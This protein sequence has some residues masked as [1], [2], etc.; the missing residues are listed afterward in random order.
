[1]EAFARMVQGTTEY[2]SFFRDALH[3]PLE[4][5]GPVLAFL[6]ERTA[7]PIALVALVHVRTVGFLA[8]AT[9]LRANTLTP[10]DADETNVVRQEHSGAVDREEVTIDRVE[11]GAGR[12]M[13][14]VHVSHYGHV[15]G[16]I[17]CRLEGKR[18]TN[19]HLL[20]DVLAPRATLGHRTGRH[21]EVGEHHVPVRESG[22][23]QRS[24]VVLVELEPLRLVLVEQYLLARLV[25]LRTEQI[26]GF[27]VRRTVGDVVT[28][29]RLLPGIE[30]DL[31]VVD[32]QNLHGFLLPQNYP[33]AR[34]AK[35]S[36]IELM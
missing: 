3:Q 31:R 16:A 14:M 21:Q 26:D 4:D 19:R 36:Q 27:F 7:A 6:Q 12:V 22:L 28:D 20:P 34:V 17:L 15:L 24:V 33:E 18:P 23:V 9:A 25:V 29:K 8:G 1:M 13:V 11:H 5:V 2:R 30:V 35:H 32:E 10:R